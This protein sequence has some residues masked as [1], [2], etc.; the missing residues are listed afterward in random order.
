MNQREP[1]PKIV[2]LAWGRIEVQRLGV[3]KEV[4]HYPG[5]GREWDWTETGT[6]S[7][8]GVQPAD[9][10]VPQLGGHSSGLLLREPGL[11]LL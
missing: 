7:R 6:P 8:A 3:H 10:E 4:K 1:S 9:L 2:S 11:R 5:G